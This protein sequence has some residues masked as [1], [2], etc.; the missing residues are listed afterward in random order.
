MR[1]LALAI[2]IFALAGVAYLSLSQPSHAEVFAAQ[3]VASAR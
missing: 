2:A 3:P 1:I